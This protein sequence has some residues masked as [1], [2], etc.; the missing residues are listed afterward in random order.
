M[1]GLDEQVAKMAM[2]SDEEKR[3]RHRKRTAEEL[4]IEG[5]MPLPGRLW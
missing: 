5:R 3:D 1:A 4:L 2:M